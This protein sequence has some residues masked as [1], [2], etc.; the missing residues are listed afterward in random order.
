MKSNISRICKSASLSLN[1]IGAL[2]NYLDK[3]S[4]ERLVHAFI[5]SKLNYCNA[6]LFG[7][8]D[9]DINRLHACCCS[10]DIWI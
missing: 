8:P 5:S 4:M 3:I 2:Y 1:K 10:A 7:L 9:R 6:L